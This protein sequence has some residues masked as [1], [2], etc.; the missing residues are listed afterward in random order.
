MIVQQTNRT[1]AVEIARA[2]LTALLDTVRGLAPDD[3]TR[4]T[5][6]EGW[7]VRDIVAHLAGASDEAVHP[8]VQARHM[9][10]AKTKLRTMP[11]ADALTHQ[12]VADRAKQSDA[13]LVGELVKLS[14]RVPRGRARIPRLLRKL[15]F[16]DPGALPGDDLGYLLDVIYTRD[17]WM[18]RIDISRAIARPMQPSGVENAV[19]AQVVRDLQRGWSGPSFTLVLTGH[20]EGSWPVGNESPSDETITEDCVALCR[21]LSGR[22]DETSLTGNADAKSARA[23]LQHHRIVF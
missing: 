21:L 5:D 6:C 16:P 9:V 2:E 10:M 18:H 19:V 3:F 8:H 23:Q 7:T 4:P 12:Q 20:V 1:E 15:P 13:D 17:I 22:S 14:P 11:I